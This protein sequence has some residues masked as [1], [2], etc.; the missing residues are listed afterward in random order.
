VCVFV[1]ECHVSSCVRV[2]EF[3]CEVQICL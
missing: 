1:C 3:E 2:V